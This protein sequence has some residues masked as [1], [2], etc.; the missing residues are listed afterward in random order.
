[1]KA[2]LKFAKFKKKK[3]FCQRNFYVGINDFKL[4]FNPDWTNLTQMMTK[5][6]NV[7]LR[8]DFELLL[9]KD[10]ANNLL[11]FQEFK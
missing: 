10:V 4:E 9:M 6:S 2:G 1:V 11:V 8:Q 7:N 3:S 5:G